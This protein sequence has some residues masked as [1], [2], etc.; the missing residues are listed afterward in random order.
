[1]VKVLWAALSLIRTHNLIN[2]CSSLV[3]KHEHEI[4]MNHQIFK[5]NRT[6]QSNLFQDN[7]DRLWESS[8]RALFK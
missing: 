7:G 5:T 8:K 4:K 3:N 6:F 1:M 2:I